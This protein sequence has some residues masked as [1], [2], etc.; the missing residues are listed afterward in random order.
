MSPDHHFRERERESRLE[1]AIERCE[2][3]EA[4]NGIYGRR[5]RER[6]R[7]KERDVGER[8]RAG[9]MEGGRETHTEREKNLTVGIKRK[10]KKKKKKKKKRLRGKKKVMER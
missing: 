8:Q 4:V 9:Y 7:K 1:G 6:D 3:C 2:P 10:K 5:E